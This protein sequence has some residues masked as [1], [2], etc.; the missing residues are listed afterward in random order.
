MLSL[1]PNA[2]GDGS[3]TYKRDRAWGAC[4]PCWR[5]LHLVGTKSDNSK[6]NILSEP[7]NLDNPD[8][9]I[10]V[11]ADV[12]FTTTDYISEFTIADYLSIEAFETTGKKVDMM[13]CGVTDVNQTC[14]SVESAFTHLSVD[15]AELTDRW[16][17]ETKACVCAD[18]TPD[19]GD[20]CSADAEHECASC[21]AGYHLTGT[22]GAQTCVANVCV[23]L[24]GSPDFKPD[25]AVDGAT[26]CA[27][28]N[29]GYHPDG[30]AGAQTCEANTC[31]CTSTGSNYNAGAAITA[32]ATG[33]D[34]TT[35]GGDICVSSGPACTC[36]NGTPDVGND[37][38]A[39]G[40]HECAS[41]DA[42]YHLDGT[43]GAQTCEANTCVCPGGTPD[44]GADCA[45]DGATEC[46]SC[47]AG[48]RLDGTAGTQTCAANTCVCT[49]AGSN[50]DGGAADITAAATGADC[51]ADGDDICVSS[52]C[53]TDIN[54]DN[55]IWPTL[56]DIT[57]FYDVYYLPCQALH[58]S[59]R[60]TAP[61]CTTLAGCASGTTDINGDN[62]MWPTLADITAFYDV[63][64]LPCQALHA[65]LRSTAPVC[66]TLNT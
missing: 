8:N 53:S 30:T 45:V 33:T 18:G 19:V 14:Y 17:A 34:C 42:G 63:Y 38:S 1:T 15:K 6:V 26:E 50:Y 9:R 65:S 20:D 49:P 41:C 57:A 51:T 2:G 31:V 21:D 58:A 47:N 60:S 28:C 66:T 13:T 44:A 27:S 29:A 10:A 23:C 62:F 64:Y 56:A 22:A 25:C 48:Y 43:A 54:G 11:G 39:E 3:L 61:V 24:N 7:Y 52:G 59:L 32:A 55:F 5:H 16:V 46:A 35:D 37:C 4:G 40:E 36:T 12:A